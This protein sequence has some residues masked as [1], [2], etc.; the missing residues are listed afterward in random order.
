M[1]NHGESDTKEDV[2]GNGHASAP[3]KRLYVYKGLL[4][5]WRIKSKSGH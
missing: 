4:E 3:L 2:K 1:L 5:H